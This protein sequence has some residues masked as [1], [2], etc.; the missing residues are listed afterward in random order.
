MTA[1]FQPF[2]PSPTG[3]ASRLALA[4]AAQ[5]AAKVLQALAERLAPREPRASAALTLPRLEFHADAGAPEGALYVDGVLF[6]HLPGVQR[7]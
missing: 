4:N 1:S 5:A 3:S 7:L 6:G 2:H